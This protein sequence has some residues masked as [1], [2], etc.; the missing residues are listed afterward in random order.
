[1]FRQAFRLSVLGAS[2]APFLVACGGG[3]NGEST[4]MDMDSMD[5]MPD[6]GT[7]WTVDAEQVRALTG[8]QAPDFADGEIPTELDRLAG[9]AN[10]ML[11]TDI[12]AAHPTAGDI[13]V[14]VSCSGDTCGSTSAEAQALLG[15]PL[16]LSVADL[17]YT[18]EDAEYQAIATHRGVSVAQGRGPTTFA[19]VSVDR[20]GFGGWLEHSF[21]AVEGGLVTDGPPLAVGAQVGY[22]YSVGHAAGTNP[23][24]GG[25]TWSGVM[26]GFDASATATRGSPI[27][28]DAE[29]SIADLADPVVGVAFTGIRNLATGTSLADMTWSD[30]ALVDGDFGAKPGGETSYIEGRFYGPNHEEVGGTFHR[31]GVIGAFGAGR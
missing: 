26:T 21:F 2:L 1:M 20:I 30:L 28:G 24:T 13:V 4:V 9:A 15:E 27:V 14:G 16:S 19:G 23:T 29:I 10:S 11:A 8:A 18:D 7:A 25:G 12:G 5:R 3:G 22:G 6:P 31:N 17:E